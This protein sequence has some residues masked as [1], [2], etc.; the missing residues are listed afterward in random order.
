MYEVVNGPR[1]TARAAALPLPGVFMS[2][3]T[4]T[5]QVRRIS[6]AE[7]AVGAH[8]R[9]DRPREERDHAL[10]VAFAPHDRPKFAVS[11]IVEHG[12]SGA[13]AAAPVARDIILRALQ[14]EPA[15]DGPPRRLEVAEGR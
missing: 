15:G 14:L 11:V 2:G 3:K 9:K 12:E 6:K 8:K 7:R 13:K 4:G 10:F 5:S 1:G